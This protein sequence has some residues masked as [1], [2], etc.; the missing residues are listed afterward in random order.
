M[1]KV[2]NASINNQKYTD[3]VKLHI[4]SNGWHWHALL[5]LQYYFAQ[6]TISKQFRLCYVV[7]KDLK[8]CFFCRELLSNQKDYGPNHLQVNNRIS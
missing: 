6:C 7:A 2:K 5:H 1:K 8:L 3:S 4:E